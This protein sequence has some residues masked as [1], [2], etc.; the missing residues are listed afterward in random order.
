MRCAPWRNVTICCED[1]SR[2]LP[3]SPLDLCVFAE[4]GYYFEPETLSRI[5]TSISD[6]LEKE[7]DFAAVHWLGSSEDHV[8]H[9]DAVHGILRSSLPL[10]WIKGE[11]HDH[12]R[13][14]HWSKA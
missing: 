7:G 12:F 2:Y 10:R 11:R 14:D 6:R 8:L 4:I 1:V 3:P 13:L 5:A 9:G